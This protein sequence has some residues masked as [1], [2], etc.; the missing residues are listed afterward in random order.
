MKTQLIL[1]SI[2]GAWVFLSLLT[3]GLCIVSAR[4]DREMHART[5]RWLAEQQHVAAGE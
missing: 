4:S 3:V 5:A 2:L 1:A